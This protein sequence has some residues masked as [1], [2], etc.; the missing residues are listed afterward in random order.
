[1]QDDNQVLF[2]LSETLDWLKYV[3]DWVDKEAA[4]SIPDMNTLLV[5][6][7]KQSLLHL[8]KSLTDLTR[9]NPC[10]VREFLKEA[11]VKCKY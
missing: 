3:I 2:S 7:R 9:L 4:V 6:A 11:L 8:L 5:P 1:M 10:S